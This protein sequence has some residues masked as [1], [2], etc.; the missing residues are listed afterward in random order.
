[1]RVFASDAAVV[2]PHLVSMLEMC[3]AGRKEV[4][5]TVASSSH[6]PVIEVRYPTCFILA[7]LGQTS[8]T[9]VAGL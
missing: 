7:W 8:S 9:Q 4:G 1:M 3:V 6:V 5:G 2:P